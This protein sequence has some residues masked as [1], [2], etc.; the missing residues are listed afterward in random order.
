MPR[1]SLWLFTAFWAC[2]SH[3]PHKTIPIQ[4]L[5]H[6]YC[7]NVQDLTP[8]SK[9]KI[10][11]LKADAETRVQQH[12]DSILCITLSMNKA[13]TVFPTA[14]FQLK[15]LRYL[16]LPMCGFRTIPPGIAQLTQLE[17]LDIN[18]GALQRLPDDFCGL[19]SLKSAN[20]LHSN[21]QELPY[22][23]G[24]LKR[25]ESLHLGFTRIHQLPEGIREITGLKS[26]LIQNTPDNPHLT[27]EAARQ[28]AEW[29]PDCEIYYKMV[30]DQ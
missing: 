19:L 5:I 16:S 6:F 30:S 13:D 15:N 11:V 4:P 27:P 25:L 3:E 12:K 17:S 21:L 14:V 26:L 23:I 24:Q 2:T 1:L 20:F 10:W 9:G 8:D 29:L 18:Y 28:I 7:Q 22:C